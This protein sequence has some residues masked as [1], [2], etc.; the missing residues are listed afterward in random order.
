MSRA[1]SRAY[2][3]LLALFLC[4]PL[5]VVMIGMRWPSAS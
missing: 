4:A 3:A 1:F 5:I 2:V